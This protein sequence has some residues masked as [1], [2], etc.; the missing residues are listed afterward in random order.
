MVWFEYVI[1]EHDKILAPVY[2]SK[3]DLGPLKT[4]EKMN[5]NTG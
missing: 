1:M 3:T 4:R 2:N 5:N